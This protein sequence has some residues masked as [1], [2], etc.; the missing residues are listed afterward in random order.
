M[1][2]S[3]NPT[4]DRL[5]VGSRNGLI[6]SF[7]N[8]PS[9]G[10][11]ETFLDLRD[12]VAVVW[13]GGFLGLVFHPDFGD[14]GSPYNK[15]FYVYY[16]SHCPLGTSGDAPDLEA[17][18][19]GY[20]RT[21]T[22]G[23][24]GTYLR[25]SRFEVFEDAIVGDPSTEQVLINIRLYNDS[26]RGG[27]MT[28][29][30]D[31]YLYVTI[32]DQ[33]RFDTAQDVVDTLEGGSVRLAVDVTDNGDGTWIC[34]PGSHQPR[35]TL[36]TSERSPVGI[37]SR[38]TIHGWMSAAAR[39]KS[40]ARSDIE[41]LTASQEIRSPIGSGPAKSEKHP[42]RRSTSSSAATTTAGPSERA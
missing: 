9:A 32:G 34:P 8:Q 7:D 15:T 22:E 42:A 17:C 1:V 16:S 25:L 29:R 18:D 27:G 41:I 36:D 30:D 6:V 24:F 33:F 11:T 37:A 21:S 19:N 39:L 35:R 2:I 10:A 31:G 26:H 4:D 20:P 3:S 28:F 5:Y 23:F 38:T 12:R 14:P 13:D 40:T